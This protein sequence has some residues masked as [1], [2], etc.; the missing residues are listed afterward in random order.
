MQTSFWMSVTDFGDVAVGAPIA[1]AVLLALVASG[2]QRGA[3]AWL[4]AVVGCATVTAACKLGFR[5][6][7]CGSHVAG[8]ALLVFS[9][10]GHAALSAVVYGG[11]ATLGGRQM[12]PMARRA[13]GLGALVWIAL[14]AGSRVEVHAHSPVEVIAGL[15]VG[16]GALVVLKKMLGPVQDS[17]VRLPQLAGSALLILCLICGASWHGQEKLRLFSDYL[18]VWEGVCTR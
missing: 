14:I 13:L 8:S 17:S 6:A 9:P 7:A 2:W 18:H 16:C 5:W 3:S 15:A 11:L 12:P 1:A 10:S 4:V